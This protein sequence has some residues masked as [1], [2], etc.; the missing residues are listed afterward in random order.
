MPKNVVAILVL[1]HFALNVSAQI[2]ES[3]VKAGLIYR[4]AQFVEWKD[5]AKL[6]TI[7][8]NLVSEDTAM[9]KEFKLI[10]KSHTL[11]NKPIRVY[12]TNKIRNNTNPQLVY[13]DE[14]FG[15]LVSE[16]QFVNKKSSVLLVTYNLND[17]LLTMINILKD[18]KDKRLTFEVN[19]QNLDDAGFKYTSDLLFYGGTLVDIKELYL[20][21]NK[22]LLL[23]SQLLDSLNYDLEVLEQEKKEYESELQNINELLDTLLFEVNR[24]E[25][26]SM[27]LSH[28]VSDKDR[29]LREMNQALNENYRQNDQL[30]FELVVQ[31]DSINKSKS[32]LY[33]LNLELQNKLFLIQE[34]QN[35]I[36]SQTIQLQ[37]QK[38]GLL[39]AISLAVA[40]V[41]A[42]VAIFIALRA[43]KNMNTRLKYLVDKRTIDLKTSQVY[44]RSLFE[45]SPVAIVEFDLTNLNQFLI[46]TKVVGNEVENQV[47]SIHIA[48]LVKTITITDLNRQSLMLFGAANK[49][50]FIERY[51]E[52]YWEESK[53]G[54]AVLF[55]NV[56]FGQTQ[57]TYENLRKTLKG[58]VRHI[59]HNFIVLPGHENDYSKVLISMLDITELKNYEKEILR[60]RDHLEDLVQERTKEIIKLNKD[61][62]LANEELQSKNED[63]SNKNKQLKK[64]QDEISD[65]NQELLETN[66]LLENQKEELEQMLNK[67]KKTQFQLIESEKMASLSM[68]TAGVAH[69]INNPIN[70][71]NGGNQALEMMVEDLWQEIEKLRI[72]ENDD[73]KNIKKALKA[74]NKTLEEGDYRNMFKEIID[75]IYLG[76][77]RTS[78]IVKSL[79]T[80]SR[81]SDDEMSKV[82]LNEVVD[83][84]LVILKNKYE[85]RIE[86]KRDISNDAA[87]ICP[88]G[89]ISQVFMNL[90]ANAFDAINEK[91]EVAIKAYLNKKYIHIEISD[92]GKGMD[93]KTIKQ[94]FDPFFTT[95]EVG[96]GTGLGLYI[97]YGIVQ[98]LQG[99]IS[100]DSKAGA[101]TTINLSF[102]VN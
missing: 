83:N 98:Q 20:Q 78:E 58:E 86:I 33:N 69:E 43:K 15:K 77:N 84:T 51:G 39:L 66:R 95:K 7:K 14:D 94:A 60:H 23:K 11:R 81:Q 102:P 54:L 44:Y 3:K 91:G 70:F 96:K 30:K 76:V 90:L 29:T 71:I 72:L 63:L 36:D 46:D 74:I 65:L 56:S 13:L 21:T 52:S 67:L 45:N 35:L 55:K 41:I 49:E 48:E 1:L 62:Y 85:N 99:N 87:I 12:L 5:E 75:G 57:F 38:K 32:A 101:G 25:M 82:D 34:N 26:E 10:E 31:Q 79:Q 50:E 42:V 8:I 24:K 59:L 47:Y 22:E 97:T 93:Q 19:K 64:Q 73:E 18:K 88:V 4:F 40:L 27:K 80:Y 53:K 68:L 9:F 100:I 16:I 17:K 6:D 37:T 2:E 92:S 61:L 89:K 28:D